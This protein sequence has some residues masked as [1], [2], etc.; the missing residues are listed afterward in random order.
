M[1]FTHYFRRPKPLAKKT[2][3]LFVADVRK[4]VKASAEKGVYLADG[5]G[6][7]GTV[8]QVDNTIVAFNGMDYSDK[9]GEDGSHETLHIPQGG[10]DGFNFCKTAQKPYDLVVIA[11]LIALKKHFPSIELSSDGDQDD[12]EE[13]IE[14]CQNTL[15]YGVGF[16]VEEGDFDDDGEIMTTEEVVKILTGIEVETITQLA[17][18][19]DIDYLEGIIKHG[20]KGFANLS[21]SDLKEAYYQATDERVVI[22]G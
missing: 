2:F 22:K 17:I 20:I 5:G 15:G 11:V 18:K 19:D 12:W 14:F 3:K 7:V 10:S 6:T 1:G 16:D 8:P 21:K 4:L 9:G 13:G